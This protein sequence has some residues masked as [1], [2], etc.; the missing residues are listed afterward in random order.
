M[1]CS[2]CRGKGLCGMPCPVIARFNK[3]KIK[4]SFIGETPPSVFV[5]R[6]GYP[7]VFAGILSVPE[8]TGVI[9][10]PETWYEMGFKIKNVLDIRSR[11]V[12]SRVKTR[13]KSANKLIEIQQ[14]IAQ[15]KKPCD[16]EIELK[17]KP[18]L[19]LHFYSYVPPVSSPAPLRRIKLVDNPKIPKIIDKVTGDYDLDAENATMLLYKR[20]VKISTI[21]KIFSF[22][23]LGVKS[24]RKLVPTRWAITGVDDIVSRSLINKI[25]EYQTIDKP[26]LFSNTYL[27]N[28]Y[29][30]LLIPRHWSYEL[31]EAKFPG[32]VWNFKGETIRLLSDYESHFGRKYYVDETA[33]GYYATR[34]GVC[35]YLHRIRRQATAFVIRECLPSYFA[36]LGVWIVRECVRHAFDKPGVEFETLEEAL[37]EMKSRLKLRWED[38]ER[39][40]KLLKEMKAQK[41]ISDFF[42]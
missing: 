31:I 22:G 9:D 8:S 16:V 26:M 23:L 18:K 27:G 14:E 34:L 24:Q 33:G 28:H 21:Q 19:K 42:H 11:L 36:P 39:K 30:I 4:E 37:A 10:E 29:E 40:S 20:N 25:K 6:F 41:T 38:I 5:G 32:S 7:N 15:S 13:V 3:M 12:Y 2:I 1:L 17:R 35:E